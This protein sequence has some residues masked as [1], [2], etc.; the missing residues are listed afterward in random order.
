[1]ISVSFTKPCVTFPFGDDKD[2]KF[3]SASAPCSAKGPCSQQTTCLRGAISYSNR[4]KA[5]KDAFN[6]QRLND[7]YQRLFMPG[8]PGGMPGICMPGI[9]CMPRIMRCIPPL[10][11][12]F[13]IIFCICLCCLSRRFT[14]AI[15]VPLPLAMRFFRE[16]LIR[17]GKATLFQ[18]HGVDDDP[19]ALELTVVDLSLRRFRDLPH[20]RQLIQ[21]T[22][23]AAHIVH[24]LELVA[25]ILQIEL[26]PTLHFLAQGAGLCPYRPYVQLLRSATAHRPC[27]KCG[28]LIDLDK[29]VPERR[30]FRPHAQKFDGLTGNRAHA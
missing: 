20:T 23:Y 16:P 7:A 1:M 30:F 5:Q 29:T 21:H 3:L 11:L 24:L 13:F 17:S 8:I 28:R 10:R 12:T 4:Q 2:T 26:A 19:H 6:D 27:P 25:E 14:S 15:C 9:P 18:G 22:G